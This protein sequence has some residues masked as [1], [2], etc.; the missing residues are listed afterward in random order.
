ASPVQG[1]QRQTTRR[2]ARVHAHPW[3]NLTPARSGRPWVTTQPAP[4]WPRRRHPTELGEVVDRD[5]TG[6]WLGTQPALRPPGAN[7]TGVRASWAGAGTPR[8]GRTV[9]RAVAVDA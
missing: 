9:G 1:Q 3:P 6:R 8:H 7:P 5:P 2:A 4:N